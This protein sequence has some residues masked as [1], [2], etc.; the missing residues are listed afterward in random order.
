MK[1]KFKLEILRGTINVVV[2]KDFTKLAKKHKLEFRDEIKY[3]DAFVFQNIKN[4][5]DYY[6]CFEEKYISFDTI[7]HEI[8]H[9][10][11]SIYIDHGI[12]HDSNND[13]WSAYFTGWLT[14]KITNILKPYLMKKLIPKVSK[15]K[16]NSNSKNKEF[17]TK[18]DNSKSDPVIDNNLSER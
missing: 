10:V 14:K 3:Y 8:E 16:R 7:S 12:F 15:E 5:L 18:V 2:K 1:S 9:L 11:N 17:K 4:R 6:I 13:E